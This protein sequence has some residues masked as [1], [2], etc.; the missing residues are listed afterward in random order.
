MHNK[1]F[2]SHS[3]GNVRDSMNSGLNYG[4]EC[5]LR[6]FLFSAVATA[7]SKLTKKSF[8]AVA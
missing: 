7:G 3:V 8:Y 5:F 4:V 1:L 6:D 2:G